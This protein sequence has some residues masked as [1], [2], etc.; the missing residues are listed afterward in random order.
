MSICVVSYSD[1][2][3]QQF[4]WVHGCTQQLPLLFAYLGNYIVTVLCNII[5][6]PN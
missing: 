4:W 5:M 3:L 6:S 2:I 1:Q